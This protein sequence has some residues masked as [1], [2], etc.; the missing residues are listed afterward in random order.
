MGLITLTE[1]ERQWLF[2]EV[3]ALYQNGYYRNQEPTLLSA[4]LD[5]LQSRE[6]TFTEQQGCY[7]QWFLNERRNVLTKLTNPNLQHILQGQN[8]RGFGIGDSG[9]PGPGG[10]GVGGS[11]SSYHFFHS[12]KQW[13]LCLAILKKLQEVGP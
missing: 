5:E 6:V 7:M 3:M 9:M 1:P 12:G 4:I 10:Q 2:A 13:Y 8:T 11:A